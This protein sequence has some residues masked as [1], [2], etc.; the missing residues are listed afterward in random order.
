MKN[1]TTATGGVASAQNRPAAERNTTRADAPLFVAL[2]RVQ[3]CKTKYG[4]RYRLAGLRWHVPEDTS[5]SPSPHTAAAGAL[6]RG[7]INWQ[8]FGAWVK[9]DAL[10]GDV[11]A[12]CIAEIALH[13]YDP[14]KNPAIVSV[15]TIAEWDLS[16]SLSSCFARV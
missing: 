16:G 14:Q 9:P 6:A 5:P 10:Q 1:E 13:A 8:E 11:S 4:D 12:P 2:Y 3:K 7:G 15:R